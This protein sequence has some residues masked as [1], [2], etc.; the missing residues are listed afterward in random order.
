MK[1]Y[2][3]MDEI[4]RHCRRYNRFRDFEFNDWKLKLE[5]IPRTTYGI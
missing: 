4:L 1:M 5:E 2:L 3:D